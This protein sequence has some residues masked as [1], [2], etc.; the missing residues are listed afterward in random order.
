MKRVVITGLGVV[1]AIGTSLPEVTQSLREGRS[2]IGIDPERKA[3]GF[4]SSLTGV[5]RGFD[6][7][8]R[9]DRKARRTMGEAA[10]YGCA[11]ALDA[12]EDAGLERASLASPDVGAIFGN[13]STCQAAEVMFSELSATGRTGALGS[14]HIIRV[15]NSTVTMNLATLLGLQGACWSLSAACASGLHAL[16][17]AAML[18]A[19][20]QQR[21]VLCGGAQETSWQGMA[22]FDALG[23]LSANDSEPAR[24]SR[25]FDSK[26][27]GLV[28][29]GGGAALVV[30][31]LDSARERGARIYAEVVSYAFGC[32]GEHLTN[33]SG[34]GATRTMTQ[35]LQ[36]A[37]VHPA[38]VDYIHAHAT[39]T[40]VGDAVEAGAIARV[41]GAARVPVSST[42]GLTGHECWMAGASEVA[43]CLLMMR[44]G[45]IAGNPHLETPDAASA[46]LNLP[47][48]TLAVR[49]RTILKNSFGFG[50]TNASVVLRAV[51]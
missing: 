40:P 11:A 25:P 39:S 28:P 6:P 13:D 36:R 34:G 5:V 33:P 38:E 20:E 41:F 2:G 50:G 16:G 35:A 51:D 24:A 43:Y 45:F 42:K 18:I 7:T 26:R 9:F 1:S 22:A 4:R 27:D 29:S 32:D 14:G 30:E 17:Q 15:M 44:E 31:S 37:H 46:V 3:R 19:T 23:A 49:P 10:A 47:V 48:S 21:V 12:I 8:R